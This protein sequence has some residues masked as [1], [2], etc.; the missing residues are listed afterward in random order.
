M[1]LAALTRRAELSKPSV[2]RLMNTLEE[3]DLVTRDPASQLYR[4]GPRLFEL[5]HQGLEQIELRHIAA[6][7]LD[8]LREATNETVHLAILDRGEV[9]YIDK[10]ESNH[11]IRMISAVGR[12]VPVHCTSLGKA[13][14]PFLLE[15]ERHALIRARPLVPA[16]KYSLTDPEA[17][18]RD[19]AEIRV[20]GYSL[21]LEEHEVD[22]CC[23]GAP[24]FD[25]T[26][27][28]VAAISVT[29]PKFRTSMERLHELG[30]EVKGVAGAL[31]AKL[32]RKCSVSH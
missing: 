13:M 7:E 32:G 10:R 15:D 11:T 19:L 18:E 1:S 28:P 3:F 30:T 24:V 2:Y 22:I 31:S 9:V 16:T 25:H 5:A 14:L 6:P 27:N 8:A 29:M 21:D 20:R 26:G 17:L 23:V 12:R 4:P